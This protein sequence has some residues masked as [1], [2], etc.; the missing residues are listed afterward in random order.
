MK[1]KLKYITLLIIFIL[2]FIASAILSFIPPEEACGGSETGCYIISQ[3]EYAQTIGINNCY[4]GL[5]AFSV[6]IIL[7]IYHI[8]K[9]KKY[10]KQLILL[11][12]IIGSIFALYFIYLQLIVIK[13]CC[14]F[15]MVV[16]IGTLLG[17]AVFLF[18]KEK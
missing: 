16:D 7:T 12:L 14:Q 10:K 18:W 8:Q 4:F 2:C 3:S 6:L 5:I 13:A 11:G 15:C 17:L 9:P 1:H